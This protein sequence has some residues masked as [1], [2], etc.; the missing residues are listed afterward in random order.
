[1]SHWAPSITA[2]GL[3]SDGSLEIVWEVD[4]FYSDP[5]APE[6]VSVDLD[7]IPYRD[8]GA[9][10][11]SIAIPP[12]DLARFQGTVLVVDVTFKWLG[13]PD[14]TKASTVSIQ[15]GAPPGPPGNGPPQPTVTIKSALPQ[16]LKHPNE[17]TL[18]W[19]SYSY[20][21]GNILWGPASTPRA[22][23][24]SIKPTQAKYSF[25]VQVKNSFTTNVWVETTIAARSAANFRSIRLFLNASGVQ[26]P[27][28]RAAIGHGGSIRQVMGI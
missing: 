3:T 18:T 17:I 19:S 23:S 26:G 1:M 16:T 11:R 4:S 24:H 2:W 22:W 14:D 27:S 9:A 10:G 12:K 7:G 25:T 6:D 8:L 15:I 5:E 20:N 28:L 21:D 13:P